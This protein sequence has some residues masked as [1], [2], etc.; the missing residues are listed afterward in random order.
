MIVSIVAFE[1]FSLID[2]NGYLDII[3]KNKIVETIQKLRKNTAYA[4]KCFIKCLKQCFSTFLSS[5]HTWRQKKFGGT[6]KT[7]KIS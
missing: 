7:S 2:L 4:K 5:R 6:Q 1:H 3:S